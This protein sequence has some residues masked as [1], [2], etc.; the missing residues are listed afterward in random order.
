MTHRISWWARLRRFV[1]STSFRRR[2]IR[3]VASRVRWRLHWRFRRQRPF[4]VP[5]HGGMT[6]ALADSSASMGIFLNGGF[7]DSSVA[8][9][10][11]EYLTPGMTAL[12]CGA[13]VGEYAAL[14]A[15]LV[16]T[17]GEVH[18]FEPDPE[19]F[20][21]LRGNMERN[22]LHNVVLNRVAVASRGGSEPFARQP[23][24]TASSLARF[25]PSPCAD[26]VE[27]AAVSLDEYAVAHGLTAVDALKVDVEGAELEVLE[28]A[29]GV[30]EEL[31]PGLVFVECDDPENTP[32]VALLLA[33]C[34][35]DVA[36]DLEHHRSPHVLARS[37]PR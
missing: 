6:M 3:A 8:C 14:F 9:S 28:G 27:V 16:G 17:A 1:V 36:V 31:R 21:Y 30:L 34:G 7:S 35:Y 11:I 10:F 26:I 5:F 33:E 15:M 32:A 19:M 22:S 23:D 25:S 20:D 37:A 12:D 18:A 4:V 29:T 24:P 13:H 2:P